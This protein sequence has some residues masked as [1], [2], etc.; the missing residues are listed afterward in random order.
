MNLSLLQRLYLISIS[1]GQAVMLA[2]LI[3][4]QAGEGTTFKTVDLNQL[5]PDEP[6]LSPQSCSLTPDEHP[7][8]FQLFSSPP[9]PPLDASAEEA[10]TQGYQIGMHSAS[11]APKSFLV[12]QYRPTGA[13]K[14]NSVDTNVGPRTKSD[15]IDSKEKRKKAP[16]KYHQHN[17]P[18]ENQSASA[19]ETANNAHRFGQI[20]KQPLKKTKS[21]PTDDDT[22]AFQ[23]E[24]SDKKIVLFNL[25]DWS[26]VV[27]TSN[28]E[29]DK[30][31]Q[32][33]ANEFM[34]SKLFRFLNQLKTEIEGEHGAR[35]EASAD[36]QNHGQM[37]FWI[38]REFATSFLSVYRSKRN[39][40]GYPTS[41]TPSERGSQIYLTVLKLVDEKL[42]LEEY[43]VF[44]QAIVGWIRSRLAHNLATIPDKTH[45]RNKPLTARIVVIERLTKCTTFL[46]LIY[47]SLLGEH[48]NEELTKGYIVDFLDFLRKLWREI[49]SGR[50]NDRL[51][52][53]T[54]FA[55]KLHDMLHFRKSWGP[56]NSSTNAMGISWDILQ[57]WATQKPIFFPECPN[58]LSELVNKIIVYSNYFTMTNAIRLLN[59][60]HYTH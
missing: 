37:Y 24:E 17:W 46:N 59:Q 38:S 47:L 6:P 13:R 49:E 18:A 50:S 53:E 52:H 9:T 3:S 34:P 23:L 44:S 48:E 56:T 16:L 5:P 2:M 42:K 45:V 21:S 15:L 60:R 36:D 11:P 58:N 54:T 35:R 41:I 28:M 4:T 55:R 51:F 14:H 10:M 26:F 31:G 29:I 27:H 33:S 12:N 57:Y 40:I 8:S 25:K 19:G 7:L 43:P 20:E 1:A 32:T 30:D 39:E 22:E